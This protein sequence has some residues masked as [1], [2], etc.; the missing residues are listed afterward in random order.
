[1]A[2][3]D[4]EKACNLDTML[5]ARLSRSK[6]NVMHELL[7]TTHPSFI[8]SSMFVGLNVLHSTPVRRI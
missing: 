2:P 1:M 3:G 7:R 5:Y 6:R 8:P 4:G